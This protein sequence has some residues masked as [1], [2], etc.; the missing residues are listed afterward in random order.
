[1]KD[2]EKSE[3]NT[4]TRDVVGVTTAGRLLVGTLPWALKSVCPLST[5]FRLS[6]ET[7]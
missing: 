4:C 2:Y 1:M 3:P 5:L 7:S 6:A